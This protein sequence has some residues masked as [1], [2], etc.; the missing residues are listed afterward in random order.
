M[1][2]IIQIQHYVFHHVSI[3][4]IHVCTDFEIITEDDW[5][6][7]HILFKSYCSLLYSVLMVADYILMSRV[8]LDVN[9]C[10]SA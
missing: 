8:A 4:S 10:I 6:P 1:P 7:F 9:V 5:I 2:R 3:E